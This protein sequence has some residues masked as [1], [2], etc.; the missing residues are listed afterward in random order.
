VISRSCEVYPFTVRIRN[1]AEDAS[2]P[3][4]IVIPGNRIEPAFRV[5]DKIP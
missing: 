5:L 4:T 1:V 2:G 3:F